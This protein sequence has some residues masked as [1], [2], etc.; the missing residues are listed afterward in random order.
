[1][2]N[3]SHIFNDLIDTYISLEQII[4][5]DNIV[6]AHQ[7]DE[8]DIEMILRAIKAY[9]GHD[10]YVYET[11][12]YDFKDDPSF[13]ED[14]SI[15]TRDYL[16]CVLMMENDGK[17]H[18]EIYINSGLGLKN[19][20]IL[21]DCWKRFCIV[22]E[23]CQIVLRSYYTKNYTFYPDTNSAKKQTKLFHNLFKYLFSMQDFDNPDYP[24]SI[25]VENA[26]EIIAILL[27]YPIDKMM[28]DLSIISNE[29]YLGVF[30]DKFYDIALSKKIPER[31]V[32]L[33]LTSPNIP[34]IADK[35]WS[36]SPDIF[37]RLDQY[38]DFFTSLVDD[39]LFSDGDDTE[40]ED[41]SIPKPKPKPWGPRIVDPI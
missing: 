18:S 2:S 12:F 7:S 28:E 27:L 15:E 26:S 39:P 30:D 23:A 32:R 24:V 41:K 40:N 5:A 6:A 1:M 33:F 10:I 20:R 35:V 17:N 22:K 37:I 11:N 31:Y 8:R 25:T 36:A 3:F 29:E 9:S 34:Q 16:S 4:R 21:N 38:V 19:Q 13:E 14:N